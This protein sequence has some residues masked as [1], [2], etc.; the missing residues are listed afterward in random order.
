MAGHRTEGDPMN[1]NDSEIKLPAD[2]IAERIVRHFQAEGFG[3]I[4][5]ALIIRIGLR[6][7]ERR[8]VDAAFE[9]AAE[10]EKMP[11]VHEHFEIHPFGHYAESRDFAA[12]RSAIQAD[13]GAGLRMELP[14]VYFDPAPIVVDDA[15]ATGTRYDAMLKI[16][17][18]V[19]GHAFAVLLN[20]PD[21]SFFEYLGSHHGRDWQRI[22]DNFEA[23]AAAFAPELVLAA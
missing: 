14:R 22:M 9:A 2:G 5:E 21:S 10:G 4:S 16:G 13:F 8:E 11:P 19:G 6:R 18:N 17:A 12:A 3:G 23:T 1:R 20:D 7:G 15:F